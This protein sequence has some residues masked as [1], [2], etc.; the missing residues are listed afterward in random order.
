MQRLPKKRRRLRAIDHRHY[1]PSTAFPGNG[2][3]PRRFQR[4]RL[5]IAGC[6][7]VGSRLARQ[8]AARL[9]PRL[10]I[11]AVT[12]DPQ[13]QQALRA[14]GAVVIAADLDDARTLRRLGSLARWLVDLAPPPAS[15]DD[16]PRS[17]RL[18]ARLART[19]RHAD[20]PA[21]WV[22]VSTTGVY[23]DCAGAR[24]DETRPV[25]PA[26]PRARRRVAAERRWRQGA[27]RLRTR[28]SI[29]RAPGIYAHD[30]LPRERLMR[31]TPVL[32]ASEDVYTNHIHAED[33]ALLCAAALWHGRPNRVYHAVD[34]NVLKMGDYFDRIADALGLP[35]PPRRSRRDIVH[36]VSPANLS[37][38]S[39]SR[40]LENGRIHRELRIRLR[41]PTLDTVLAGL[42]PSADPDGWKPPRE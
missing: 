29:L 18:C 2:C 42:A 12:R 11:F 15:G 22:Y 20:P 24:F 27:R 13:R 5:L 8:L 10:R 38:M 16:D 30:R 35:R 37:F 3:L 34:D 28:L 41:H 26:S 4:P 31:G 9:G 23:G 36:E 19:G 33:L 7:D 6:G 17:R 14:L 1:P 39:E 40:R 25:R 21:R 32:Q